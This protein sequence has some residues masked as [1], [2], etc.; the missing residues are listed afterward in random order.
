MLGHLKIVPDFSY[1]DMEF[2]TLDYTH[3]A[4]DDVDFYFIRNTTG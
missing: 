4:K 1:A 2:Y 3:Y